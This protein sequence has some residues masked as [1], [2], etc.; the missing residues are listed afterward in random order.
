MRSMLNQFYKF[1]AKKLVNFLEEQNLKGGERFF[2]QFDEEKNVKDFYMILGDLPEANEFIYAHEFGSP[3]KTFSLQI[4]NVRVI[5]AA[6]I[7]GVTPDFLVT[8]RNLVSDQEGEWENTALIS[9]S[10]LS[11]DSIKGGSKDLQQT[12]MPFHVESITEYIKE[13]LNH[14]NELSASEKEIIK[15]HLGKKLEDIVVQTTIW[16]YAE[17]IALINKGKIE[18]EDFQS[19][20]LFPDKELGKD[21]F[22]KPKEITSRLEENFRLF[23]LVQRLHDYE[24]VDTELEK[25]FE[26]KMIDKLKQE[27]WFTNEFSRVKNA[28]DNVKRYLEYLDSETKKLNKDVIF[29]E[30]PQSETKAGRRKRHIIIFNED[31]APYVQML[32]EFDDFLKKQFIDKKT[33]SFATTSGKKLKVILP[34]T[35]EISFFKIKYKHNGENQSNYEFNFCIVPFSEDQLTGIETLYELKITNSDQYILLDYQDE[36]TTIGI[37]A[38]EKRYEIQDGYETIEKNKDEK[39][40]LS[41]DPRAWDDDFVTFNMVIEGQFIRFV[42]K[43]TDIKTYPITANRVW[44]LKRE[45][46]EHFYLENDRLKQGTATYYPHEDFKNLLLIEQEWIRYKYLFINGDEFVTENVIPDEVYEHY[47]SYLGYFEKYDRLPSLTYF[48]EELKILAEKYVTSVIESIHAIEEDSLLFEQEKNL[49]KLGTIKKN[50]SIYLTPLHPLNVAYQLALEKTVGDEELDYSI[51]NRLHPK[52]LLP[53]IYSDKDKLYRPTMSSDYPEWHEYAP[54]QLVT[55]GSANKFLA[56]VVEEKI[57]QFIHHFDYLFFDNAQAPLLLNVIQIN[58]DREVVRGICSFL[59][60]ELETKGPE[61]MIPIRVGIYRKDIQSP[62]YFEIFSSLK[63]P[64]EVQSKFNIDL[65]SKK[66][67]SVD[68]LRLIREHI[69]YYKNKL[70]TATEFS[71]AHISFYKLPTQD[72]DASHPV[73]KL[74][75]GVFLDGLLSS[76][77]SIASETDYRTGFGLLNAPEEKNSLI[78]LAA[79][80]NE[81][82]FNMKNEGI[83]SYIK[84]KSIVLSTSM[85]GKHLLEKLYD[86]SNW[87]TFID[88]GVDLDFFLQSSSDVL[89]IHYSDQYTSSDSYDAITVTNKSDQYKQVIKGY[90]TEKV[91]LSNE[92]IERMIR[93]FNSI[94]GEWLLRIIGSKGFYAREKISLIS[95]MKFLESYFYHPNI[96]WIPISLEEILRVASATKL[97]Q[98]NSIFT[99]KNLKSTGVHSDDI[100]LMGVEEIEDMLYVHVYPVEV[101][102]GN[103]QSAKAKSQIEK[104]ARLLRKSLIDESGEHSFKKKF[105]RN[106]F[107]QI[108]LSNAKKLHSNQIWSDEQYEKVHQLKIRL[109]NDDF[110]IGQHLE[111]YIGQGAILSFKKDNSFRSALVENN[112]LKLNFLE[113]DIFAGLAK[114]KEQIIDEMIQGLMDFRQENLLYHAYKPEHIIVEKE[115]PIHEDMN[116][117]QDEIHTELNVLTGDDFDETGNDNQNEVAS[118]SLEVVDED[119]ETVANVPDNGETELMSDDSSVSLFEEEE[120]S[121]DGTKPDL[122][123]IRIPIGSIAGSNQ[124]LYWEYGHPQLVNRHLLITGR[125]GQGKTYF[126]QCLLWELSKNGI[127]SIVI[128]YTDGYKKSQLE[129]EFKEKLGSKLEQFIVLAKK[130]PVNPFKRNQIIID[131]DIT[132]PEDD[133]DVADRIK[134][135]IGYIYPTLGPQQL[136]AIYQAVMKGM[137]RYDEKMNLSILRELLEEDGSGPAKTALSQMNLLIDKNPFDYENSM[138]WSFLEKEKGKVFIIQLTGYSPDVQKMITEFILWDLWNYKLQHGKKDLPFPVVLDESQRLDF[139]ANAPSS[140]ILVEGR[141][142]GWSG[143]FS[144]QFLKGFAGDAVSRLQNSAVKVYFAPMENEVSSIATYLTQDNVERKEWESRLKGLQKGQ[145]VFYGP[146]Q[147]RDGNLLPARPYVVEIYPFDL[148]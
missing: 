8:L 131:E 93:S 111:K 20:N 97:N 16:D 69:H 72:I 65:S 41:I 10:H 42:M 36:E 116:Q 39:I 119:Q 12:G 141:K 62:S 37:G 140:K 96:T 67:D 94:N 82:S 73:D 133:S 123:K 35:D 58:N 120:I 50:G 61:R 40:V 89:V 63:T 105:F 43:D 29:W 87:V 124:T 108:L 28:H 33:A 143:W 81:L 11:L 83:N 103:V 15:F 135:V 21:S 59:K 121:E 145:C 13:E 1:M 32:F 79:L 128:D 77:V 130:F 18:K 136:N 148:R 95:A 114:E 70:D 54:D 49:F 112:I 91:Q 51:L 125:S 76:V 146:I 52:N 126:I 31:R 107:A 122:S 90:I 64:D 19:L 57:K 4:G 117:E 14:N 2:L 138:D 139:N 106:F 115:I 100:L 147:D 55:V 45:N 26:E 48:D 71:Y 134:S 88:P 60:N 68:V 144:T 132:H 113:G 75:T 109:M 34:C 104:T 22:L 86:S 66:F 30:K 53:F 27:D 85:E 99:A 80:Y 137:A 47:L 101:K 17:I 110:T 5:V 46:Q 74:E 78:S 23:E 24:T 7:D 142:F 102:T 127:S 6:T 44:K 56:N 129:D 38:Y 98:T 3:Y 92:K 118:D 9:I 84:G 25:Y